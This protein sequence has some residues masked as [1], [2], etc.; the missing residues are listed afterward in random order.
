MHRAE[1]REIVCRAL[2][3]HGATNAGLVKVGRWLPE[4]FGRAV[5][6]CYRDESRA[7]SAVFRKR[8]FDIFTDNAGVV[9]Q[10]LR[11]MDNLDTTAHDLQFGSVTLLPA[12]AQANADLRMQP[13][14]P[15]ADI[16]CLAVVM[17]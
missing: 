4:S 14:W 8:P 1:M 7:R 15:G 6:N 5:A 16:Q 9:E 11:F 13:I 12:P 2:A 17:Y 10:T 3:Q